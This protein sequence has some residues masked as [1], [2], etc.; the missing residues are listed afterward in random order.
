MFT[1]HSLGAGLAYTIASALAAGTDILTAADLPAGVTFGTPSWRHV[2]RRKSIPEPSVALANR[3]FVPLRDEWDPVPH[4]ALADHGLLGTQCT[5]PSPEP[6]ACKICFGPKAQSWA[7]GAC[8]M[9][10]HKYAHYIYTD[11]PGPKA[12]CAPVDPGRPNARARVQSK[13]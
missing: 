1:G 10:R 2:L 12:A 6:L 5:W 11:V 8:F 7:C 13:L 9:E 4:A 3:R